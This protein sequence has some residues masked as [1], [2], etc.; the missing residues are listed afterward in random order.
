[1]QLSYIL[2][3]RKYFLGLFINQTVGKGGYPLIL[4]MT[5]AVHDC[6]FNY[7][8]V[9]TNIWMI[10]LFVGIC[11][12]TITMLLKHI[13]QVRIYESKKW[14]LKKLDLYFVTASHTAD[15]GN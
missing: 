5:I 13:L 2:S 11:L 7:F 3:N 6:C 15:V 1:M 14:F 9:Y 12:R 10:D 8:R 4:I